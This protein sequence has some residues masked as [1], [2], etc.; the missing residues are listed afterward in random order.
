MHQQPRVG[1]VL[2]PLLEDAARRGVLQ[3]LDEPGAVHEPDLAPAPGPPRCPARRRG[4]SCPRRGSPRTGRS[5]PARRT[6]GSRAPRS[7]RA[8]PTAGSP[9]RS[10]PALDVGEPRRPYA[11]V[12][13][14]WPPGRR[15]RRASSPRGRRRSPAR[16]RRPSSRSRAGDAAISCSPSAERFACALIEGLPSAT[17]PI[18]PLRASRAARGWRARP[19]R[20]PR[21]PGPASPRA[22]ARSGR[23]RS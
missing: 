6:S 21:R 23:G 7:R 14:S 13:R 20:C 18:T 19:R 1:V 15:P 5:R 16:P 12:G 3:V 22:P 2:E 4:A 10:P 8:G 17:A 9:S 11:L